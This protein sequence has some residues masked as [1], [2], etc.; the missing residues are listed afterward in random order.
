MI[1]FKE[2]YINFQLQIPEERIENF[3][4]T[5]EKTSGCGSS[6]SAILEGER[7][8]FPKIHFNPA[9]ILNLMKIFQKKSVLFS[10][11]GGVHSATIV[12]N[13]QIIFFADDIGRHNAVDKVIGM[14]ILENID[15]QNTIL[16][17][18]GRISSEIVKKTVRLRI[19]L[20]VSQSA[21]TSEAIR[22]AWNHKMY[23]IGFTRSNRFNIYTGFDLL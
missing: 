14:S 22:L 7:K 1:T 21:P 15:L 2:K 10:Q 13:E 4:G 18:S 5:G 8:E 11:T 6:L 19:P 23:L 3:L 17:S 12:Q 16:F 20:I 9:N